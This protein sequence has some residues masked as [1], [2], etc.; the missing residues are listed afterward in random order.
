MGGATFCG[1]E[2]ER[3]HI[4]RILFGGQTDE[5]DFHSAGLDYD[6]L[7]GFLQVTGFCEI[8]RRKGGFG[9]FD[10]GSEMVHPPGGKHISVSVHARACKPGEKVEIRIEADDTGKYYM[11]AEA[12]F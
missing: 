10:D 5:H 9:L 7:A 2:H 11:P 1:A 12:S 8:R 4:M 6:T 3:F